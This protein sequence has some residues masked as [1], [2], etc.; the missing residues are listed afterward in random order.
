LASYLER[1]LEL[2]KWEEKKGVFAEAMN[3]LDLER[4]K[5]HVRLK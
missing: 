1:K 2:L 5:E 4:K 3:K